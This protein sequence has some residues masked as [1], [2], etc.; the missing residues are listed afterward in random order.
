MARE[1]PPGGGGIPP[2]APPA[3]FGGAAP[4]PPQHQPPQP[5]QQ[6]PSVP[7][8]GVEKPVFETTHQGGIDQE[9]ERDEDHRRRIEQREKKQKEE[10]RMQEMHT[11]PPQVQRQ[12][13]PVQQQQHQ[14]VGGEPPEPTHPPTHAPPPPP[15]PPL[16]HRPPLPPG[17][18]PHPLVSDEF[19][20]SLRFSEWRP[21]RP[22]PPQPNGTAAE[23]V[24]VDED[25][26]PIG[27]GVDQ[28]PGGAVQ[29]G[30]I[31]PVRRI[32]DRD[33]EMQDAAP[34]AS[35][36]APAAA[37]APASK[38]GSVRERER[39]WGGE[40][41]GERSSGGGGGGG[42]GHQERP[43]SVQ[44]DEL[45]VEDA[46][47]YLARVRKKFSEDDPRYI[48]FL[49]IMK[50][51]RSGG[52]RTDKVIKK[53]SNLFQGHRSL[54][55]DFN[56][57]LPS[58]M[59]I[60]TPTVDYDHALEYVKRI[61]T[62]APDKY[63]HFIEELQNYQSM[64]KPVKDVWKS[65]DHLM[66][67][68]PDLLEEFSYF[69]PDV[70]ARIRASKD[71]EERD[72]KK[73]KKER[74]P[75]V[76]A[77]DLPPGTSWQDAAERDEEDGPGGLLH[78]GWS[79]EDVRS[80]LTLN[81]GE[82]G[83]FKALKACLNPDA[84]DS[85]H[86]QHYT[87]M[88][89]CIKLFQTGVATVAETL[90]LLEDILPLHDYPPLM[91][92]VRKIICPREAARRKHSYFC[93]SLGQIDFKDAEISGSSYRKLPK[94]YPKKY[95]S[96]RDELCKKEL[97]DTWISIPQ[98]S[99]DLSFR[100]MR[101]NEYEEVLFK[102]EDERFD[103]DYVLDLVRTTIKL[104]KKVVD[105]IEGQQRKNAVT[106]Q[107]QQQQQPPQV[108]QAQAAPPQPQQ[109]PQSV[110]PAA[111]A[112]LP[113]PPQPSQPPPP[114]A[115]AAAA[116]TP[117]VPPTHPPG[118]PQPPP[119]PVPPAPAAVAASASASSAAAEGGGGV[120][121]PDEFD[122]PLHQKCLRL[123]YGEH[124][125]EIA[126]LMAK[127]PQGAVPVIYNRLK[128][129]QE[130]WESVQQQLNRDLWRD[131]V[132]RNYERSL[133]HRSFYFRSQD[134]KNTT[135]KAFLQEVRRKYYE[136][137]GGA[138]G[139]VIIVSDDLKE[140]TI[141]HPP[142]THTGGKKGAGKP[143]LVYAYGHPSHP[144]L[145]DE[146]SEMEQEP[147]KE[148]GREGE[149][150]KQKQQDSS[151]MRGRPPQPT[152]PP[153]QPQ[154]APAPA[155]QRP[156][157]AAAGAAAEKR[158]PEHFPPEYTFEMP[159]IQ[160]HRDVTELILHTARSPRNN[161]VSR[162]DVPQIEKFVSWIFKDFFLLGG[163]L[164]DDSK[165]TDLPPLP[166]GLKTHPHPTATT[167]DTQPA[168]AAAAA[169][170]PPS[171]H[172]AAIGRP[173]GLLKP[174]KSGG[175]R[176]W[177]DTTG[178]KLMRAFI[179]TTTTDERE[180][181][182]AAVKAEEAEAEG[183]EEVPMAS[184]ELSSEPGP[185]A[186]LSLS[187]QPSPAAPSGPV[188]ME[189]DTFAS[190]PPAPAAAAAAAELRPYDGGVKDGGGK[191][192]TVMVPAYPRYMIAGDTGYCLFRFYATIY[193]RLLKCKR[194]QEASGRTNRRPS[195]T[196]SVLEGQQERRADSVLTICRKLIM[197][198]IDSHAFEDQASDLLGTSAY[199]LYTIDRV[200]NQFVKMIL[201]TIKDATAMKLVLLYL[202]YRDCLDTLHG[203][204][205]ALAVYEADAREVLGDAPYFHLRYDPSKLQF[206][207]HMV[208][209][210]DYQHA[211]KPADRPVSLG[212][213]VPMSEW[214]RDNYIRL[215]NHDMMTASDPDAFKDINMGSLTQ[216]ASPSPSQLLEQGRPARFLIRNRARVQRAIKKRTQ[217]GGQADKSMLVNRL[218]QRVP[219]S[220]YKFVYVPF[221]ADIYLRQRKRKRED[222]EQH[223]I[224]KEAKR[225][226]RLQEWVSGRVEE[227]QAEM[228][229]QEAAMEA[230][231]AAAEAEAEAEAERQRG[232]DT[233]M[234]LGGVAVGTAMDEE[235][236]KLSR[237][238][239]LLAS[240]RM[241]SQ[242]PKK[243]KQRDPRESPDP[244]DAHDLLDMPF[245][246]FHSTP[247]PP[248]PPAAAAA[249]AAAAH[250]A[251][252]PF[253]QLGDGAAVANGVPLLQ[254]R[255]GVEE[256]EEVEPGPRPPGG[257]TKKT[258]L[259]MPHI[260]G[261]HGGR[262]IWE[263]QL[264]DRDDE[265]EGDGPPPPPPPPA[266]AAPPPG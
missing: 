3:P 96:G 178:L 21:F 209:T 262:R 57:F 45:R 144:R 140:I 108:P 112:A 20:P 26:T 78:N 193:E 12:Q 240:I 161:F 244:P 51:F 39:E 67:T 231:A 219:H 118:P 84:K 220:S 7:P 223:L 132:D 250:P 260:P 252:P 102:T 15:P 119:A 4:W 249:A 235:Q 259:L 239:H 243:H 133:D 70:T 154:P 28:I 129:K 196:P 212:E 103:L 35:V 29:H 254:R 136:A 11:Q 167:A 18:R 158:A 236:R 53:V 151:V 8:P 176:R 205:R 152:A 187:A 69:L 148:E 174:K 87:E 68:H 111:S 42:G 149:G 121:M 114:A 92:A 37:S 228:E 73:G 194:S 113:P 47:V 89:K 120:E 226:R 145:E 229:A 58:E 255:G 184:V 181:P 192:K 54:I 175:K 43:R 100:V 218:L 204:D 155:E 74:P 207:V 206:T 61:K 33:V 147:D 173:A 222:Q 200:C 9:R 188:P 163:L 82:D 81:R 156:A 14:H 230:A 142:D 251:M 162:H 88:A 40:R 75:P 105:Q 71:D 122:H 191:K 171:P 210:R 247:P 77:F 2:P 98:G 234:R 10:R 34:A 256:M 198:E 91:W 125:K 257:R 138:E 141:Q 177:N 97:N 48:E 168:A 64:R 238:A 180:Q 203:S 36:A 110:A 90:A 94:K 190:G 185:P 63:E 127:N 233:G 157:A 213:N 146:D 134:R 109:P 137:R 245:P 150:G 164:D 160:T 85:P 182:E 195:P 66:K 225:S 6:Q 258:A 201:Y 246:P 93:L 106:D 116:I 32:V 237:D 264:D 241:A 166:P 221:T 101:R 117:D 189:I 22:Q 46:K 165:K 13:Q 139:G 17:A 159:D 49:G 253:Q 25:S 186:P 107:Q 143:Q 27:G 179:P 56:Q 172:E 23:P 80:G 217:E 99:E 30:G 1:V 72:K 19:P 5:H 170:A 24:T 62:L 65:V 44:R 126:D 216:P 83:F 248:P 261:Y 183:T 95:C 153:T 211:I 224:E 266:A 52:L 263:G 55:V 128:Q 41:E 214:I 135:T 197:G 169:V 60:G 242:S 123:I 131:M 50:E 202:N 199:I 31:K 76:G 124:Y 115:A 208:T 38:Q 265:G 104:L 215:V 16:P 79:D 59:R 86:K 227:I 130:E 232:M